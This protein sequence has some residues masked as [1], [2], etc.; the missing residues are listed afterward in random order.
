MC[1]GLGTLGKNSIAPGTQVIEEEKVLF[2]RHAVFPF[3]FF[4]AKKK[5]SVLR[6]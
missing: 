5:R 3:S 6:R 1:S 2:S 4:D